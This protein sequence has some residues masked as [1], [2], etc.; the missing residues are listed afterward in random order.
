M[1]AA[2]KEGNV[3]CYCWHFAT[4]QDKWVRDSFKAATGIELELMRFSGTISLERVKTEA[5]AGKFIADAYQAVASYNVGG[6]DPTGLSKPIDNLPALREVANLNVWRY[7]PVIT[8]LTLELPKGSAGMAYPAG[9]YT[10]NTNLVP[11]ERLPKKR[12]DL[13]D[14]WWKGKLCETDPITY[15]GI[16]Y[17]VWGRV[18]ELGYP[19]WY[20]DFIYDYFYKS[21]RHYLI[22]LGGPSA[23]NKGDCALNATWMGA[24]GAGEAKAT[25]LEDKATWIKIE[26]FDPPL[27]GRPT[28]TNGLSVLAKSPHPNAALV[29]ANW[30]M[31]K[32]SQEAWAKMGYGSVNR[33]DVKHQ[34]E[35]KYWPQKLATQFWAPEAQWLNFENYSY[36]NKGGVFK[37]MKEGMSREAWVKWMKDTSTA[38]WGQYP[39]PPTEFFTWE[40]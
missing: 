4:W 6:L 36:S 34:I 39:P 20:P 12:Q 14:P 18:R 31:S 9:N 8:P 24:T 19:D 3:T 2:K 5:R 7:S 17:A 21:Q 26:S 35:E 37:L 25:H 33:R 15:A 30:L 29:F 38:Y 10:Y 40:P 32:E 27:P 16:D 22:I 23:L 1:E 28:S 11:P 13:L